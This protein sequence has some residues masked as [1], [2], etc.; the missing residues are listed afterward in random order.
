VRSIASPSWIERALG[1]APVPVPPVAV[2]VSRDALSLAVF[3]SEGG[4]LVL[5][6]FD[7][8]ELPPTVFSN[9]PLGGPVNDAGALDA[10]VASLLARVSGRHPR[11]SVVLPDAWARGMTV[12]LDE[13]PAAPDLAREILRF[14]L[15]KMVPFRVEELRLSAAPI[16]RLADQQDGLRTLVLLA[17]EGICAA[18]EE[19]FSRHHVRVGQIVNQTLARLQ[20]LAVGGR[21]PGLAAL[22]TVEPEGFAVVFARDGAPVVWRQKSF[23]DGLADADRARLLAAELRLTRTFLA[24]R[25]AGEQLAAALLAAPTSVEGFWKQVLEEGLNH[26]VV[27]MGPAHL[28]LAL[29]ASVPAALLAPLVG[30]ASREVA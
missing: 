14:R 22:A 13:L 2:A 23:T 11:V 28:P 15:R 4:G 27:S 18:L 7:S 8:V 6:D 9:G 1:F 16:E 25:L 3:R 10:A 29:D 5:R 12:E 30:A 21:L 26:P 17:A 24:E 20:A 19:A